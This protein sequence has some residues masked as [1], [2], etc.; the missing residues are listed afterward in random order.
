MPPLLTWF[1]GR[2]VVARVF[3]LQPLAVPGA[4]RLVPVAANGQVAFASYLRERD[5]AYRAH[6]LTLPTVGATGIARI[7]TFRNPGLFRLFGL[8]DDY[9]ADVAGPAPAQHPAVPPWPR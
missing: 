2:Q 3:A 9:G 6:A 8:P 7:V 4:L 5:G 1:T